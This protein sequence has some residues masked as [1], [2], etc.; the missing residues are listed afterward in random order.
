MPVEEKEARSIMGRGAS[1]AD[2]IV[3]W[4]VDLRQRV[5][6]VLLGWGVG[7]P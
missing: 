6:N 3:S 4:S 1:G 7:S 2:A 5:E